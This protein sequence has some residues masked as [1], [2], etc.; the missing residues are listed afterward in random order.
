MTEEEAAV[1][2]VASA[3]AKVE[4]RA[5]AAGVGAGTGISVGQERLQLMLRFTMAAMLQYGE[6]LLD[7][8]IA[9]LFTCLFTVQ[10]VA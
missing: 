10:F 8:G 7:G 9:S 6:C 2:A 4:G 3:A 1:V 5:A